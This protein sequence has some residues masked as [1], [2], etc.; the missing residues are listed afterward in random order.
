MVSRLKPEELIDMQ[1]TGECSQP[2]K[3]KL[4]SIGITPTGYISIGV[5]PMGIVA[6]GI[7]PMGL[8]SFGTVAMGTIAGGLVS[9][10][11]ISV[12]IET[13]SLVNLGKW[14]VGPVEIRSEPHDHTNHDSHQHHN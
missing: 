13:M 5:A 9:M 10:G 7:V 12:G 6:I 2:K 1:A 8:I 14:Q 4:I 11:V 3:R